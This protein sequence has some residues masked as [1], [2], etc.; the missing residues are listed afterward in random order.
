[1]LLKLIFSN[2][3]CITLRLKKID[4]NHYFHIYCDIRN[5]VSCILS[6]TLYNFRKDRGRKE[7]SQYR[8]YK[9]YKK[10]FAKYGWK[11]L[12]MGGHLTCSKMQFLIWNSVLCSQDVL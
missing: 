10:P 1:M 12:D 4:I 5:D 6:F 11:V 2:F 8:F 3:F 7:S 9:I